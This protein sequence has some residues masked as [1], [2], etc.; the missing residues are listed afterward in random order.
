MRKGCTFAHGPQELEAWN[1][2][3]KTMENEMETKNEEEKENEQK[4]DEN[5]NAIKTITRS[6][7]KDDRPVPTYKVRSVVCHISC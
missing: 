2:H 7:I 1:K 3:V 5:E 4:K 6:P